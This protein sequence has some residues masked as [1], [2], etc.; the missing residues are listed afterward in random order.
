MT[1]E[2]GSEGTTKANTLRGKERQKSWD[3]E[4][5]GSSGKDLLPPD[6]LE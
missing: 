4:H 6:N 5:T 3:G 1:G 2:D